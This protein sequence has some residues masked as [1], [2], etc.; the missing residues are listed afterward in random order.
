MGLQDIRVRVTKGDIEE[1]ANSI[2]WKDIRRELISWKGGFEAER[3]SVVE[4]AATENPSTDALLL[5]LGDINGRIKAVDYML[6]IPEIFIGVLETEK[7]KS[8]EPE[9]EDE[10]N[11]ELLD[12]LDE[13]DELLEEKDELDELEL[14]L[15]AVKV[16]S[17]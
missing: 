12:E 17:I 11:D 2:L 1:F 6:G 7:S 8:S 13:D 4:R 15:E 14:E 16:Y 10:L 9:Q 3:A 5:H